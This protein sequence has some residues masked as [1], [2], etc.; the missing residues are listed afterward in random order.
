L[1]TSAGARGRGSGAG[2]NPPAERRVAAPRLQQK[3]Y[4]ATL[5]RSPTPSQF[6]REKTCAWNEVVSVY[7]AAHKLGGA[8]ALGPPAATRRRRTWWA[9]LDWIFVKF[10]EGR[11]PTVVRGLYFS[12]HLGAHLCREVTPQLEPII[13]QNFAHTTHPEFEKLFS[14]SGRIKIRPR[15]HGNLTMRERAAHARGPAIEIRQASPMYGNLQKYAAAESRYRIVDA[16]GK[17]FGGADSF[18]RRAARDKYVRA[19]GK[20]STILERVFAPVVVSRQSQRPIGLA[21]TCP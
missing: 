4:S 1:S 8:G 17:S 13:H 5:L 12:A 9:V 16:S 11:P 15:T 7:R 10:V 14:L 2:P 20:S 21:E 3:R 19:G 6:L 18:V